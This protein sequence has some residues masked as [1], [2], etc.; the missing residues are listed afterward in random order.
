MGRRKFLTFGMLIVLIFSS[1]PVVSENHGVEAPEILVAWKTNGQQQ[2]SIVFDDDSMYAAE[3]NITI[4][5]TEG[6][7]FPDI[8]LEWAIV[9]NRSI[10][11]VTTD[12]ILQWSDDV[13][14]KVIVQAKD[15]VE[16]TPPVEVSRS[17][18]V[19]IWNQPI[20]DHEITLQTTWSLAQNYTNEYG[21]Q[22]FDLTFEGEGWQQRIGETLYSWELGS[23]QLWSIEN[24]D[25]DST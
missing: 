23:G 1:I 20:D 9:E 11:H 15:G 17:F 14:I 25:A 3:T 22:V 18:V 7:V 21:L 19:G 12:Y 8:E 10:L 24:T 16:L 5:S 4:E 13:E 6:L 2:Y